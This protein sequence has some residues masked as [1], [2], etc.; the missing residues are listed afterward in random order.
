VPSVVSSDFP[1]VA[2]TDWQAHLYKWRDM[3]R[4]DMAVAY[5]QLPALR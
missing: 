1:G 3:K 2:R 4:L 5:L